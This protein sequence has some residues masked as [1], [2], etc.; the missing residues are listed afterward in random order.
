[1]VSEIPPS[2]STKPHLVPIIVQVLIST[3]VLIVT[4]SLL[5]SLRRGG[6]G[7]GGEGRGG[8]GRGG[9]GRGGEG[10]EGGK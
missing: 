6:E 7:R 10:R 8:E 3:G 1:M 4:S 9:E 2:Y 5:L